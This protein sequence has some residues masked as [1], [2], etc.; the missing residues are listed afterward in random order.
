MATER[1]LLVNAEI[2]VRDICLFLWLSVNPCG[3]HQIHQ[4]IV[5]YFCLQFIF[6]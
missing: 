3:S 4:E 2:L 5:W 6:F 1:V